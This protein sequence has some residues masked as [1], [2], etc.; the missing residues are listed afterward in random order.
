L[1]VEISRS[2]TRLIRWA[3]NASGMRLRRIRGIGYRP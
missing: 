3:I 2:R 1:E